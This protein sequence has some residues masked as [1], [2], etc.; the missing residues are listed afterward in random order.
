VRGGR[1]LGWSAGCVRVRSVRVRGG[2]G[3]DFSNSCGCGAG[4]NFAGAAKKFQPAHDSSGLPQLADA[5]SLHY[6]PR[7]MRSACY[8]T[9]GK[10]ASVA[11]LL[12]RKTPEFTLKKKQKIMKNPRHTKCLKNVKTKLEKHTTGTCT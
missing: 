11:T 1:G 5:V 7:R 9:C 2:W 6:L 12:W 10:T 8:I 3:Q 4:L